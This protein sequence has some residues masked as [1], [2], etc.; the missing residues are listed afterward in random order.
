M[1]PDADPGDP[2]TH[3]DSTYPDTNPEH[4]FKQVLFCQCRGF[5]VR[6]QHML[7]TFICTSTYT[8]SVLLFGITLKFTDYYHC[9]E[10][11]RE[12]YWECGST[13]L[14]TVNIL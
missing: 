8:T 6:L 11:N 5:I 3:M 1:N 7:I 13:N 10:N 12:N 14:L 9:E 4:F 2:K